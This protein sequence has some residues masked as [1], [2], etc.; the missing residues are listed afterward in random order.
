MRTGASARDATCGSIGKSGASESLTWQAASGKGYIE[1]HSLARIG[2]ASFASLLPIALA[3]MN[4]L[5]TTVEIST[6]PLSLPSCLHVENFA[7]A[8]KSAALPRREFIAN[9]ARIR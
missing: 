7:S 5:K 6:N 3:V 9:G 4:A 8:W 1:L 2:F